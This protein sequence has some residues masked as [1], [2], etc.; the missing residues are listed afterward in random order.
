MSDKP[1]PIDQALNLFFF[2]PLGL[3]LN[4]DEIIPQLVEKGRQQVQICLLYTSDAAD[5]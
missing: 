1:S 4:A 2:A 3:L 5:E